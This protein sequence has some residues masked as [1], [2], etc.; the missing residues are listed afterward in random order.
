MA[1]VVKDRVLET[2]NTNGTGTF[3]LAGAVNGFQA[4]S[5]IGVGN[6]TYYA[7]TEETNNQWEVGLGTVGS[8]TL[9]RDTVLSS[10]NSGNKVDFADGLKQVFCD[11]PASKAV[12][13]DGAGTIVGLG[14][15]A[16]QNANAVA[17]TGGTLNGVAIGGTTAGDGFFDVLSS[18]AGNLN[19]TI[20]STSPNTGAF[21]YISTSSTTSTTPTLS[22][23]ASNSPFASGA[24]VS[25]S[26]LQALL[27]NKSGTAGASTNYVLSNDLGTDSTYYGEFGMNSSVYSSGTPADFFSINNGI[28]FSGHD[29]DLSVG[30]GNGYKTYLAWGTSGDKAH[31]INATGAIGLNT[32]ITGTT[33]FGTSGQM[34]LSAGSAA[35]PTWSSSPTISGGTI[36]N[37]V[38][39]GTTPAAGTFTTIIGQTEVLKGTG[40]NLLTYSQTFANGVWAGSTATRADNQTTAPNGTSTA[41]TFT[42]VNTTYGG[43][44]RQTITLITTTY[45][46]SAYVKKNN[47]RYVGFRFGNV[48][49]GDRFAFF[50]FD[51]ATTNTAGISGATLTATDVGSGWYRLVLTCLNPSGVNNLIDIS[52]TASDGSCFTNLGA[53]QIVYIWGVQLEI[54]STANTYIPTTTTAI[55][56]TPTLSFSGVAGLGLQSDGSLY[57]SSAGTG[58]IRFYTNNVSLEQMRISSTTSAVDY[59]QVTGATT[60]SKVVAISAQGSDTDVTLSLAPKGAGT[61]RFGTYTAGIL[62][63]AGYITITDSGGTSRRLLVG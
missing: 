54:G 31:V 44:L 62:T 18:N 55:Y 5:V 14:T 47:Y 1:L 4:F 7:I 40:Q 27:Q 51:T 26:Y 49:N 35:T 3:T 12:Y 15:M 2:S 10:S 22:F 48:V 25:G 23:N 38:I 57:A 8:G 42:T 21:T 24:T 11:Y 50:D 60:A 46:L 17:I 43:L 63:P 32:N 34:L 19:G 59:V 33:N 28:Y 58:N 45:T 16:T 36:D 41:G 20:G 37:T 29:G 53:G 61:I 30:S 52:T 13:K 56:G 6:T 39:G 9:T